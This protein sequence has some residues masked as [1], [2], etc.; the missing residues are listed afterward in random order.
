MKSEYRR[1]ARK[2]VAAAAV[3]VAMCIPSTP[4]MAQQGNA[5]WNP[6]SGY[7]QECGWM[8]W[9]IKFI[10]FCQCQILPPVIIH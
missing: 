4:L 9:W 3:T 10:G 6:V 7:C 8:D 5:M 1:S 2:W